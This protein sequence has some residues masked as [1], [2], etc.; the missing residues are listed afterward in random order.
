MISLSLLSVLSLLSPA[1][2]SAVSGEIEIHQLS[3]EGIPP[4]PAAASN[5][6]ISLVVWLDASHLTANGTDVL[7]TR[8]GADGKVLDASPIVLARDTAGRNQGEP[9]VASAGGDFLVS[10]TDYPN[11]ALDLVAVRVRGSDGAVLDAT[12][13]LLAHGTS[14]DY[15]AALAADGAG[16][17]AAWT[18]DH[19]GQGTDV[20]GTR[21]AAD[22][23]RVDAASFLIAGGAGDQSQPGLASDGR[24][25][26][27]TWTDYATGP[28]VRSALIENGRVASAAAL[29]ASKGAQSSVSSNGET[30]LVAWRDLRSAQSDNVEPHQHHKLL[31]IVANVLA[32]V[33][34]PL[35]VEP[36]VRG[37]VFG[38]L[39]APRRT[40][41]RLRRLTAFGTGTNSQPLSVTRRSS[42]PSNARGDSWRCSRMSCAITISNGPSDNPSG[43]PVVDAYARG[44]IENLAA[45]VTGLVPRIGKS[46]I[47]RAAIPELLE[48]GGL[49][50]RAGS[51]V[52][53]ATAAR[54][55]TEN[56]QRR[57]TMRARRRLD[58][59]RERECL[60]YGHDRPRRLV[61]Y[62]TAFHRASTTCCTAS[63]RAGSGRCREP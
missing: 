11:G 27:A 41:I 40:V 42:S 34:A 44:V 50:Q 19:A 45:V 14:H 56:G 37:K 9:A 1:S 16:F 24:N 5:G 55:M 61:H 38:R 59:A 51:K 21:I 8:V 25:Y 47:G 57:L 20:V 4:A 18:E 33:A 29:V 31:P 30:Y 17:L 63:P 62:A 36:E 54:Y 58:V 10:W 12:P 46:V 15:Q 6:A 3:P 48:D 2:A 13:L 22:G 28:S 39:V 53:D 35:T 52:E 49:V 32:D 7:A 26:L 43:D 60:R 23:T